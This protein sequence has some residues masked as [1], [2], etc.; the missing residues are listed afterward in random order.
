MT[1]TGTLISSVDGERRF[2]TLVTAAIAIVV[3]I[4]FARTFFFRTLFSEAQSYAAPEPI[5]YVHGFIFTAWMGLLVIQAILIRA[6]R[7][8]IHRLFGW[9]GVGIAE[10]VE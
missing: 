8:V 6:Q 3:L 10:V 9:I 4:G 2:F 1:S 7:V 5:F